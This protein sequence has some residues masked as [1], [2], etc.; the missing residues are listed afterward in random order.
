[1]SKRVLVVGG[2]GFLGSRTV[3][4]L[5]RV[6][7]VAVTI[8]SRRSETCVDLSDP[9]TFSAVDGFDV[10]VNCA[11][12][13]GAPPDAAIRH[14]VGAGG[15]FVESTADASTYARILSA[16]LQGAGTVVL[17]AGLF[18][19]VSNLLAAD[20]ARALAQCEGVEVGVRFSPL[21]GC[22]P[23][24]VDMLVDLLEKPVSAGPALPFPSGSR[25]TLRTEV[26]E[27][28]L[29]PRSLGLEAAGMTFAP[30]PGFLRLFALLA[31]KLPRFLFANPLTRLLNRLAL[32][33][34]RSVLLRWRPI[35]VELVAVARGGGEQAV[36]QARADD[37]FA[38][39][40]HA[41][42]ACVGRLLESGPPRAGVVT[43]DEAIGL[44]ETA[45]RMAAQGSPLG[46]V[47]QPIS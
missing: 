32:R 21:S 6:S 42:A 33:L 20:A 16:E 40:A 7:G 31:G 15:V 29:L 46:L 35:E 45:R 5:E 3:A 47:A 43:I 1:M 23:G 8:A 44:E 12:T 30:V 22:G 39:T 25:A 9:A 28:L 24:T 2:K 26:S 41:I 17:G 11:D 18:P 14:V 38:A 36:R 10:V 13:I 37:G 19:G 4:A 34:L 27:T